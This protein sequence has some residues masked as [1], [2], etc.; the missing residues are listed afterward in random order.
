MM[1]DKFPD[2]IHLIDAG[3]RGS[4]RIFRLAKRHRFISSRGVITAPENMITDGAS[5]PRIF[6][7]FLDPFSSYF[8]AAITHDFLY[9]DGNHNFTRK[10]SD[11]IFL[12]AMKEAKVSYV[13]RK[14]IY[15]SVRVGGGRS[16]R[17]LKA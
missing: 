6:W 11:E 7:S 10:E 15:R 2:E 8:A 14:L 12:E 17:G 13:M 1:S 4:S 9:S 3:M 5:V 16:F